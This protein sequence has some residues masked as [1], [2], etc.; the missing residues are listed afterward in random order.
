MPF[1]RKYPRYF[2]HVLLERAKADVRCR[3]AINTPMFTTAATPEILT[4]VEH[5]IPLKRT[6]GPEEVARLAI[7]LLSDDSSYSTGGVHAVD[8]GVLS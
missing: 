3:G 8:G 1:H 6:G 4:E 7:Y 2:C 5:G